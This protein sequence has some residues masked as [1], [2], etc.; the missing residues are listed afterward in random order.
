LRV[1]ARGPIVETS[2]Y[3]VAYECVDDSPQAIRNAAPD[4]PLH[5]SVLIRRPLPPVAYLSD[6]HPHLAFRTVQLNGSLRIS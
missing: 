3:A 1:P 4:L 2:D 5:R 6:F